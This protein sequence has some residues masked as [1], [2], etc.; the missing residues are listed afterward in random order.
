MVVE[1]NIEDVAYTFKVD[2]NQESE[3]I[4]QN[5]ALVE[6]NGL[7]Q[8]KLITY[9]MTPEFANLYHADLKDISQFEG[10][11]TILDLSENNCCGQ[12]SITIPIS[13]GGDSESYDNGIGSGGS[14]GSSGGSTG[15]WGIGYSGSYGGASGGW[16]SSGVVSGSGNGNSSTDDEEDEWIEVSSSPRYFFRLSNNP[17]SP[18][19]QDPRDLCCIFDIGIYEEALF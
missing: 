17:I 10:N 6:K 14:Y 5:L 19:S 18:T 4:F 9:E 13:G 3:T 7:T 15:G 16:G 2:S 8:T 12:N 11:I 1:N